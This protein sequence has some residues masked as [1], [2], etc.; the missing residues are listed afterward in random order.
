MVTRV[1]AIV[2]AIALVLIFAHAARSAN[3]TPEN[4]VNAASAAWQSASTSGQAVL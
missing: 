1:I 4:C 3:V 2:I